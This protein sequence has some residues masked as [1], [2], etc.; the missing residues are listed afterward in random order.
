MP[1][2]TAAIVD[3]VARAC[4]KVKPVPED[5]QR[6]ELEWIWGLGYRALDEHLESFSD[7]LFTDILLDDGLILFP[8]SRD[9]TNI[10]L[11]TANAPIGFI[12]FRKPIQDLYEGS[13]SFEYLVLPVDPANK[14]APVLLISPVPPQ[15]T[16]SSTV[17]KILM[18]WGYRASTFGSLCSSFVD[19]VITSPATGATFTP[20]G[21]DF[22]RLRYVHERWA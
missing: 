2:P 1:V 12:K 22:R 21:F 6:C 18:R 8:N 13:T 7:C 10:Y 14:I 20:R 15:L 9:I 11:A 19:L 3:T 17:D 5:E 16:I 4:N